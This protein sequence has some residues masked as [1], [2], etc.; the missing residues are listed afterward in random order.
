M[1]LERAGTMMRKPAGHNLDKPPRSR[2]GGCFY[3]LC[4]RRPFPGS[5]PKW[6]PPPHL[7]ATAMHPK[8]GTNS[9]REPKWGAQERKLKSL[10]CSGLSHCSSERQPFISSR[11]LWINVSVMRHAEGAC[12]PVIVFLQRV[13]FK[14]GIRAWTMLK[15][16]Y[17]RNWNFISE[18]SRNGLEL[19][20][21]VR[22]DRC[23][24]RGKG[25]R[26]RRRVM[27]VATCSSGATLGGQVAMPASGRGREKMN[28]PLSWDPWP[29]IS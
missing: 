9:G 17:K 16:N 26:K 10:G 7:P 23:W 18:F 5:R 13:W 28:P 4:Q 2:A 19:R 20:R 21:L 12:H 8:W 14:V 3:D 27:G 6:S 15:Y 1:A 11:K 24:Q 22:A 29:S 25:E